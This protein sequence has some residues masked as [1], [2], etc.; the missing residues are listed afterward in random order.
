MSDDKF[1]RVFQTVDPARRA[2]LKKLVLS[3]VFT[4]PIIASFSVDALAGAGANGGFSNM[5]TTTSI[6]TTTSTT[7]V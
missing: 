1:E 3:A 2:I 5:T 7:T 6:K 4:V